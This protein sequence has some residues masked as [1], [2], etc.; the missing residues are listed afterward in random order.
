MHIYI[1]IYIIVCT[2]DKLSQHL[3]TSTGPE[4][5]DLDRA[6]GR[7]GRRAP[8]NRRGLHLLGRREAPLIVILLMNYT[9]IQHTIYNTITYHIMIVMRLTLYLG[10]AFRPPGPS[11]GRPM[12]GR[13]ADLGCRVCPASSAVSEREEQIL[14][15]WRGPFQNPHQLGG[16]SASDYRSRGR[17]SSQWFSS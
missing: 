6:G 8:L 10:A 3:P 17:A 11:P 1:Y 13:A 15:C 12:L 4:P 5:R 9:I 2:T 7:D 14:L 16:L